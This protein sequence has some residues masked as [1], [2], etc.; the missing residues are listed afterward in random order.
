MKKNLD[1][2]NE[3]GYDS[4]DFYNIRVNPFSIRFQGTFTTK[5]LFKYKELGYEFN[6]KSI[7]ED[8][9]FIEAEK[10]YVSIILTF[11]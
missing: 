10:D 8:S 1:K 7:T 6:F 5:T 9:F 11:E 4:N 3:L 2:L